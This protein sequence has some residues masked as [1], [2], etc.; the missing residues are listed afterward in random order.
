MSYAFERR[1]LQVAIAIG[2]LVPV[3][4]GFEGLISGLGAP[5]VFE[6]S[7]YRYLSGLL[8][9]IGAA[10]WWTIRLIDERGLVFRLLTFIVVV[11]GLA[12]LGAALSVGGGTAVYAALAMELIVTPSLCLWRERVERMDRGRVPGYRGPWE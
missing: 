5:G 4:A 2:G 6:D 12:R 8:L 10:F 11:G 1:A 9:A 7:H 3:G